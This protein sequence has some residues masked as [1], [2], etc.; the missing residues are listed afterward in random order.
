MLE[1]IVAVGNYIVGKGYPIGKDNKL[2]WKNSNDLKWFRQNTEGNIVI[3]GRKT[4]ESIGKPLP[5][6]INIVISRQD[7]PS[8]DNLIWMKSIEDAIKYCE[9]SFS[10]KKVFLTGGASI[11]QY[12]IEHHLVDKI[13]IDYLLFLFHHLGLFP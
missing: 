4:F 7:N 10:N 1:I 12:A 8:A 13:H 11:Y 3:M 2:P 6:R 5:N 9:D